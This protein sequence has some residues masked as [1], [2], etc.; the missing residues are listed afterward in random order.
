MLSQKARGLVKDVLFM[1]LV[2][3]AMSGFYLGFAYAERYRALTQAYLV[4]SE[5]LIQILN[6][7]AEKAQPVSD[8]GE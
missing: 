5:A 7:Q 4:Q 2:A 3:A 8:A 6:Q 1:S